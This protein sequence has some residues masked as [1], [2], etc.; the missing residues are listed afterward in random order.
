MK[1]PS[2]TSPKKQI[3]S[4][5]KQIP[6]SRFSSALMRRRINPLAAG[7]HVSLRDRQ[8]FT[9]TDLCISKENIPP[10]V[11]AT[12]HMIHRTLVFNTYWP[13]HTQQ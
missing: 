5:K 2:I 3:P 13:R 8:F 11:A 7:L 6:S 10:I 9:H 12:H 4:S 1:A